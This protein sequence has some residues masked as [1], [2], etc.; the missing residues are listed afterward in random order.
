MSRTATSI[1]IFPASILDRSRTS[2]MTPRRCVVLARTRGD[3]ALRQFVEAQ[4]AQLVPF[5]LDR[6][7]TEAV[8][9]WRFRPAMQGGQP[10]SGEVQVPI[11]FNAERFNLVYGVITSLLAILLWLYLALLLALVGAVVAAEVSSR[12]QSAALAREALAHEALAHEAA[13]A[14]EDPLPSL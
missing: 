12:M 5:T 4:S 6:A 7:A 14:D 1:S 10:V 13:A 9:R 3:S 2:L 11:T 8:K